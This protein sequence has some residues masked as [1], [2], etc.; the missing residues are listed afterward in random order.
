MGRKFFEKE[1][2]TILSS[3]KKKKLQK[4]DC[5]KDDVGKGLH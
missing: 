3:S 5:Y 4:I 1:A 2:N